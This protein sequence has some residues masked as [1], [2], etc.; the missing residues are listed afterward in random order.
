MKKTLSLVLVMLLMFSMAVTPMAFAEVVVDESDTVNGDTFDE[1]VTVTGTGNNIYVTVNGDVTITDP[2]ERVL[3]TGSADVTVDGNVTVNTTSADA[4]VIITSL[5]EVDDSGNHHS[6]GA[7]DVTVT[8]DVSS[9][10]PVSVNGEPG[11]SLTVE[12]SMEVI[13]NGGATPLDV[14]DSTVTVGGGLTVTGEVSASDPVIHVQNG[15]LTVEGGVT[16]DGMIQVGENAEVAI[17]GDVNSSA[18][19]T[20]LYAE[21]AEIT[22]DGNV[23]LSDTAAAGSAAVNANENG[24]ITVNGDVTAENI[25][26]YVNGNNSSVTVDGNV[27]G[28]VVG[29]RGG[30]AEVTGDVNG[31]VN[32]YGSSVTVGG[33]VSAGGAMQIA[34]W[35]AGEGSSVDIQG[36]VSGDINVAN[37]A[38][39]N[40]QGDVNG[41]AGAYA[42]DASLTIEGNV[43]NSDDT[44]MGIGVTAQSGGVTKV[45]GDV[46]AQNGIFATA[47]AGMAASKI[48]VE[49]TVTSSDNAIMVQVWTPRGATVDPVDEVIESLPQII[50][51][52]LKPEGDFVMVNMSN[53]YSDVDRAAITEGL[54]QQ[55]NYIVNKE[56]IDEATIAVYGTE[57]VDGYVVAKENSKITLKSTDSGYVLVNVSA[58]QY[59]DVTDNGDGS[60][61]ITVNRGGDLKL[62]AQIRAIPAENTAADTAA[63]AYW[64][65]VNQVNTNAGEADPV[66]AENTAAG[67]ILVPNYDADTLTI[68]MT[69]AVAVTVDVST[70]NLYAANGAGETVII[71]TSA[72]DYEMDRAEFLNLIGNGRRITLRVDGNSL[73]I[74]VDNVLVTTLSMR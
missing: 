23:T 68:N 34:V 70:I 52:T 19:H 21:N 62:S 8:G 30:T 15:S 18:S 17:A 55:I 13:G 4:S 40:V 54:I 33:S 9:T 58:G 41:M 53:E 48:T 43:T 3:V 2:A 71:H 14:I 56:N 49:G 47:Q 28:D 39:V 66:I 74:Y 6:L 10:A 50:V 57:V 64:Y 46:T 69:T 72:G 45:E 16:T 25:A 65:Y 36:D 67:T 32:A 20:A 42:E 11:S 44:G 1:N 63:A 22:V 7:A 51:D 38:R 35:A 60:Y 61:T 59:A 24:S 31:R 27:T 12:G 26:V 37:Y 5:E 73:R 29:Q